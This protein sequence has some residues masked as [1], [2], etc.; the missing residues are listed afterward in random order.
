M[1]PEPFDLVIRGGTIGTSEGHFEADLAIR[2]EKIAA[3]GQGLAA[4]MRE[5][6]ARGKFV[7]PGGIDAH[8]HIEQISSGGIM[9]ADTFES[10]TASAAFGGTTTVMPFAAQNRG[11]DLRKVVDDY[12]ALARRGAM[13]DYAFHMI[14]ANPDAKTLHEDL[15]A[16]IGEG[17]ASIKVF[18]TYDL[19]RIED[20]ALL[21]LMLAAR[22]G[23]AM[24]CVHAENHGMI[25]WMTKQLLARGYTAPKY[26]AISH[27]RGSE[28]EAI[29][30][31][32]AAA[33]LVDQPIMIFHVSTE[34]GVAV[35]REAR[36]RGI[37]VFAETCPQYLF[38]TRHDLDKPGMEGAKWMCSP[39]PREK[40]DQDALWRALALGDLQTVS[41]D[42]APYRYDETGKLSAGPDAN[43][44][45]I[46]NGLPGLETR[47][48]LL[49]DALVSRG[50]P[51]FPGRGLEAFVELT[52]TAPARIYNLPGKGAI[53]PGYDAD[54]AIWDPRK[55]V[56]ISETA[57]HSLTG[58]TP[59]EGM[60]V[61]GWPERVMVRG[62]DVVAEGKLVASPGS[63]RWLARKG[64][65][66]ALPAGRLTA[67]M[68]PESNFGASILE[69][70][71]GS[72]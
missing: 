12:A 1:T 48:P 57:M 17:H 41:S 63:G 47:L 62:R 28:A 67:D 4:G 59:F 66:A 49:Y 65:P 70:A 21:D 5:I 14:V 68:N 58:F 8:A 71:R 46:A 72:L 55:R 32:I 30:R 54:I 15:P 25:S 31:L 45:Q 51:E 69:P 3:I 2:G 38:L 34:E 26:H 36:G 44:K 29:T 40:A 22:Q 60:T 16:L 9:N 10:G 53:R 37:K 18:M 7:L 52:A 23:Q 19:I 39:P 6:D 43:F 35:I 56:T 64:G 42:H 50:R 27:P 11:L 13:V 20:E 33:T 61:T 24:L